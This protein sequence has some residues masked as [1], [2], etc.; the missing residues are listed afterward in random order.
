[1]TIAEKLK[2]IAEKLKEVFNA[3]KN[4]GKA[5]GIEEGREAEYNDFWDSYQDRGIRSSGNYMCASG[6]WNDSTFKPK[7]S[8]REL[9]NCANMFNTC[10]ITDLK[11]I[12]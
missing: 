8:L 4:K 2:T 7:Y 12:F 11:G 1:M 5:E 6:G 9:T 3:G 10:K